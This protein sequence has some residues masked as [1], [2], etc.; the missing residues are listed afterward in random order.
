MLKKMFS[1]FLCVAIVAVA[2]I[3]TPFSVSANGVTPTVRIE[4]KTLNLTSR[5]MFTAF[6]KGYDPANIN[7]STVEC[8]G[9][10]AVR[11]IVAGDTFIVKFKRQDLVGMSAG[12]AVTLTVTGEF[13]GGG[14]FALSDNIRV[15]DKSRSNQK[16]S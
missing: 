5:G 13:Y 10:P 14:T 4:P 2:L 7:V 16:H 3:A 12:E 15:K 9:A 8:E 1:L 11:G 6:I